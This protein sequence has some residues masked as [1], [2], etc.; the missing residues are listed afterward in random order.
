M[1]G[2]T[3]LYVGM[4]TTGNARHLAM[5]SVLVRAIRHFA[6][7]VGGHDCRVYIVVDLG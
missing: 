4:R 2:H 3:G 6:A 5:L 1:G 7:F